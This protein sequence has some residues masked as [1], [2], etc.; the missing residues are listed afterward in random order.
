MDLNKLFFEKENYSL[1][2]KC[3]LK[4]DPGHF[5]F[6]PRLIFTD[7]DNIMNP[8]AL[9][10]DTEEYLA[11]LFSINSHNT[12]FEGNYDV[13]NPCYDLPKDLCFR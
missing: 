2:T 1:L 4:Y 10:F 12:M 6:K 13:T 3:S 11:D 9:D 5:S 7:C 8:K